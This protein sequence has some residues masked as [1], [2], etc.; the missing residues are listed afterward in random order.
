MRSYSER[1]SIRRWCRSAFDHWRGEER[2]DDREHLFFG[3][4]AP[5]DADHL[6]VV[7][8]ARQFRRLDAPPQRAP[9]TGHLVRGDLLAVAR[10][11]EHDAE[12]V[13]IGDCLLRRGDAERRVVVVGVVGVRPAVDGLVPVGREVLD[14]PLLELEARMVGSQVDAHGGHTGRAHTGHCAVGATQSKVGGSVR[15]RLSSQKCG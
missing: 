5:T 10:S 11:T 2:V 9:H 4:H 3:V 13:R 8:L 12:A 6:R 1:M 15:L 14:D 7:V